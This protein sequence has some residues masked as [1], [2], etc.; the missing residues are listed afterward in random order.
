MRHKTSL[1]V[2]ENVNRTLTDIA[3]K[4]GGGKVAVGFL[5]GST[6]DDEGGTPVAS[7]AYWNEFG[8]GGNFPSPPRSFFRTMIA[9][10]SPKWA[11]VMATYAKAANFD[12][13]KVLGLMGEYIGGDLKESIINTNSPP[14]SH[15][16]LVLRKRFWGH[17]GDIR[18]SDVLAAQHGGKEASGTQAK[19]LVVTGHMLASVGFEVKEG[20]FFQNADTGKWE[21]KVE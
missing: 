11:G 19:P 21:M 1:S 15:T 17:M 16:T 7:V 13:A 18:I 5:E 20:Q 8:H 3:R 6:Y 10:E 14:L 9:K 2:A 12:G 4:M